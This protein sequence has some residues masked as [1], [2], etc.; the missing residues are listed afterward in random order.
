[1]SLVTEALA[2]PKEHSELYL[3]VA[4][5]MRPQVCVS[6]VYVTK[7]WVLYVPGAVGLFVKVPQR[8][9]RCCTIA[10]VAPSATSSTRPS[11]REVNRARRVSCDSG[12]S[13]RTSVLLRRLAVIYHL[14]TASLTSPRRATFAVH[15]FIFRIRP[16]AV[17]SQP[18]S[19]QQS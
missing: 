6:G 15:I 7:E 17:A 19:S 1:M 13:M 9:A 14:R 4:K 10:D 5:G 11:L 3:T 12:A 2:P 16:A 8:R 18:C